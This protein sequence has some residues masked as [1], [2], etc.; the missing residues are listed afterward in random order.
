MEHKFVVMKDQV[1]YTYS[2][3]QQIPLDFDH[4]IEFLPAIPP[5]PHT[6]A[7][8]EEIDSWNGRFQQLMEIE[9]ACSSK[10]R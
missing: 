10:K 7:Q 5:G 6:H 2:E 9:R 8:H 1:L 3:W 4:V